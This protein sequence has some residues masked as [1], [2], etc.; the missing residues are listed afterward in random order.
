MNKQVTFGHILTIL[1]I[2]VLPLIIWGINVE[3]RFERVIIN[4]AEIEVLKVN[5]TK[6]R[7][8]IQNNHLQIMG[9]LHLIE[10]QLK[11]KKDR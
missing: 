5:Q 9:Q 7:G 1:G 3:R 2:I 4:T 8:I 11:D 10:L 6:F